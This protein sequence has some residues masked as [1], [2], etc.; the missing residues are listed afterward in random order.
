MDPD[1]LK[2]STTAEQIVEKVIL[3][4]EGQQ[5]SGNRVKWKINFNKNNARVYKATVVDEL[6]SGLTLDEDKGITIEN[7]G[8][9]IEEKVNLKSSSP[10]A[11]FTKLEGGGAQTVSYELENTA[12][13][14]N[15]KIHFAEDFQQAYQIS[16]ETKVDK[17]SPLVPVGGGSAK[18]GVKNTA[19]VKVSYPLVEGEGPSEVPMLPAVTTVPFETAFLEK[20]TNGVDKKKALLSWVL[21]TST[22][23]E[24]YEKAIIEDTIA[25]DSNLYDLHIKYGEKE[26]FSGKQNASFFTT[27]KTETILGN[28]DHQPMADIGVNIFPMP[29]RMEESCVSGLSD[30]MTV[31]RT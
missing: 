13:G 4:K 10:S 5:I 28:D 11:N 27:T 21:E 7:L 6:S 8:D 20:K 19:R 16:F 14:S 1:P 22:K 9:G 24:D 23:G 25:S 12:S 15:I 3:K 26:I 29:Q 30:V 2:T 18:K 31:T 17:S